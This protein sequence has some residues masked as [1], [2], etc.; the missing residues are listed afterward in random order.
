MPSSGIRL[1]KWFGIQIR[2]DW[3]LLVIFVLVATSLAAG[4]FPS[5]HPDWT[6]ATCWA[7]AVVATILFLASILV[8]ELAHA[9]VGKAYQIPVRSI[10]LLLFGGIA[11]IEQD[12]DAPGPEAVMAAVG[13]ATSIVLGLVFT[14]LAGLLT[15]PALAEAEDPQVVLASLSPAATL[16]AWLGPINIFI[17]FFNLLPAFPLDGGRILRA[18]LWAI[19]GS[20]ER[21]T[22]WA[23]WVGQLIA[24]CLII[25]GI[26]MAFGMVVPFFGGGLAS[27]MWLA[28][29]GWFLSSA[30]G[31][32]YRQ[33]V[34]RRLLED[35]PIARL[36]RRRLPSPLPASVSVATFV[37]EHLLPSGDALFPVEDA[38]QVIGVVTAR[39]VRSLPRNMWAVTPIRSIAA[40]LRDFPSVQG[41]TDA[42]EVLRMLSRV[43][44]EEVVVLDQGTLAGVVR[45]D[46]ILKWLD[47]HPRE[48]TGP[49]PL[50]PPLAH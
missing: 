21:A 35:V 31:A 38:G 28:F 3:S 29:I 18:S 45:R 13:P 40:S 22:R 46:D 37:D 43:D 17:G 26:G 7:T 25:I 39:E 49:R 27:G 41:T 47:L 33:V 30:A 2:L 11:D 20:V 32:S 50:A 5:W 9:L 14:F 8:H 4:L 42:F 44:T 48:H 19:T 12:P 23:A 34:L 1:G 24:W 15:G 6:P 36:M 10:T 16:L